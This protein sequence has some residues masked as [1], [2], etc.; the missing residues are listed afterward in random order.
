MSALARTPDFTIRGASRGIRQFRRLR[1]LF[2]S[3]LRSRQRRAERE[4]AIYLG[5]TT[6]RI[7]DEV[8]RRMSERLMSGSSFRG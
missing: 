6:G 4:I 8:E 3:F 2:D 1:R 7:T 5:I